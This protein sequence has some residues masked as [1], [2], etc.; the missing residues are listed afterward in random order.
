VNAYLPSSG[1][2]KPTSEREV[3]TVLDLRELERVVFEALNPDQRGV[4]ET[5]IQDELSHPEAAAVLD[6]PEGTVKS[7]V[8]AAKQ[9]ILEIAKR[10]L[11][12]SQRHLK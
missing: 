6:I 3:E 4:V 10:I 5:V 1:S 9:R 11:P 7:R 8:L 12:K 2:E